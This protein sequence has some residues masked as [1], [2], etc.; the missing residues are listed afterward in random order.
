[1]S[2]PKFK[3]GDI[4]TANSEGLRVKIVEIVPS[5]GQPTY[6]GA[7]TFGEFSE[8]VYIVIGLNKYIER[9][10]GSIYRDPVSDADLRYKLVRTSPCKHRVKSK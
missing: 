1:M 2:I 8:N 5:F 6:P 7:T 9:P 10:T 3:V 4:C